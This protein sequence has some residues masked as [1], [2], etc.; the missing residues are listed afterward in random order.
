MA[1]CQHPIRI[2]NYLLCISNFQSKTMYLQSSSSLH[3]FPCL[4]N[5]LQT[6]AFITFSI[7]LN[8][9][10]DNVAS[11]SSK[12]KLSRIWSYTSWLSSLS[13]SFIWIMKSLPSRIK[14][15][16]VEEKAMGD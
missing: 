14:K 6:W 8:V 5:I 16:V 1:N 3:Q 13:T 2:T 12:L 7:D 10:I 15:I 11:Y 4:L 9:D